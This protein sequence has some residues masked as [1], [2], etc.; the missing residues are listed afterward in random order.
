VRIGVAI[1][2]DRRMY[3]KIINANSDNM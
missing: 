1:D 2:E 3:L